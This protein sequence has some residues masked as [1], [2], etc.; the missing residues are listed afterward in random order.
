MPLST[1]GER[2]LFGGVPAAGEPM[3][4]DEDLFTLF[5]VA[6]DEAIDEATMDNL[7][8]EILAAPPTPSP[9]ASTLMGNEAE[10]PRRDQGLA[11]AKTDADVGKEVGREIQ[12]LFDLGSVAGTTLGL[13][14]DGLP[15]APAE[16]GGSA[17]LELDLGVWEA[18]IGLAQPVF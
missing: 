8:H 10:V 16:D 11:D 6:T 18:A 12:R 14:I 4:T 7:F 5:G 17:A 13:T 3:R 15:P 2:L 1:G 9:S